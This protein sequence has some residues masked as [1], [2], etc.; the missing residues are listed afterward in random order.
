MI[1]PEKAGVSKAGQQL[2]VRFPSS[3]E[4]MSGASSEGKMVT[5]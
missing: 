4:Y 1:I 2:P 3:R 5:K